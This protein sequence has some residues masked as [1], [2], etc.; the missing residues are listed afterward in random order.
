MPAFGE[1]YV[2]DPN[3]IVEKYVTNL[4]QPST[5]SFVGDDILVLEYHTGNVR[6]VKNGILQ[7]KPVIHFDVATKFEQGLLGITTKDS[8]VFL[9]LTAAESQG[10]DA[11]ENRIYRFTWNGN[12]FQDELL[13]HKLPVHSWGI[14]NGGAMLTSEDGTV[15]AVI[16]EVEKLLLRGIDREYHDDKGIIFRVEVNEFDFLSPKFDIKKNNYIAMGIR[17]SF[18][19]AEDPITGHI[20]DTENGF[21]DNDEINLMKPKTNSGWPKVQGLA[22]ETELEKLPNYQGFE[23]SDPEFTWETPVAPTGITFV[24]SK[25]FN[26]FGDSVFV[27]DFNTGTLYK[28]KLN[29][30]RTG[31]IFDDPKLKDLVL[32]EE[33]NSQEI[34]FSSGYAGITDLEFGPDGLLYIVSIGDGTIYR[35]IPSDFLIKHREVKLSELMKNNAMEWSKKQNDDTTFIQ[36]IQN[37]IENDIIRISSLPEDVEITGNFIPTWFKKN[38]GWLADELISDEEFVYGIEFLIEKGTIHLT[39]Y[40]T[41]C[42]VPLGRG[43]DLSGCDLSGKVFPEIDMS[44]SNLKNSNLANAKFEKTR[45]ILADFSGANLSNAVFNNPSLQGAKFHKSVLKGIFLEGADLTGSTMTYADLTEAKLSKAD[46]KKSNFQNAILTHADLRGANFRF[47]HF[48]NAD[49]M[50]ANLS[51]ADGK[52][53]YLANANFMGANLKNAILGFSNMENSIFVDADLSGTGLRYSQ[54]KNADLTGANLTGTFFYDTNLQDAI[55]EPFTGC[56]EHPLCRD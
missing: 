3:F 23:Y 14:H 48:T 39:K 49:L 5:M 16:G 47:S 13:V 27:G 44:F 32:N 9:Y 38:A 33:E 35:V 56:I 37:M 10:G 34:V 31:F 40:A 42:D 17:N 25:L 43:V 51:D 45:M 52:F 46:L 28:F 41:K 18:G 11:I 4:E 6:L 24:N 29:S 55:G 36:N 15:Y 22:N 8:S 50:G 12:S 21:T 53:S 7:D 2:L 26:E 54:I 1:P 19:I 30:E 20:W